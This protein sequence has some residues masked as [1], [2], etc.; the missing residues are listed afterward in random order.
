M[1]FYLKQLEI[2]FRLTDQQ[3]QAGMIRIHSE[4]FQV[5]ARIAQ[6]HAL[7]AH[8]DQGELMDWLGSFDSPPKKTF[9]V[10]GEAK[11][12]HAL[13]KLIVSHLGWDAIIPQRAASFKL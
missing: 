1:E 3:S 9:V 7:S 12:S 2:C 13:Q 5:R 11:S 4:S 6:V 10:H 8:T